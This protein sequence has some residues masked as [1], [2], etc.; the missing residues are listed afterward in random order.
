[1]RT[2]QFVIET[3]AEA[4]SQLQEVDPIDR[5]L[6]QTVMYNSWVAYSFHKEKRK[7]TKDVFEKN[8]AALIKFINYI[9]LP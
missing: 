7:Q 6:E 5:L 3:G 1:M 8:E 9:P 4:K 2:V